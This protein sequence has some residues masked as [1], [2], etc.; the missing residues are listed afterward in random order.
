MKIPQEKSMFS[1]ILLTISM[2]ACFAF[3]TISMLN[4][5]CLW[6]KDFRRLYKFFDDAIKNWQKGDWSVAVRIRF[7]FTLQDANDFS[8]LY[9]GTVNASVDRGVNDKSQGLRNK[10]SSCRKNFNRSGIQTGS[11]TYRKTLYILFNFTQRDWVTGKK[12][13][14]LDFTGR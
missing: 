11:F 5:I 7:I 9:L 8:M 2:G 1:R 13:W 10:L 3:F 12:N 14:E 6:K 4:I